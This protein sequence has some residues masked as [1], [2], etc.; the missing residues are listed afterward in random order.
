MRF[1]CCQNSRTLHI[2]EKL[3]VKEEINGETKHVNEAVE[4][5]PNSIKPEEIMGE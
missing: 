4:S 2:Q 3:E 5:K 1:L